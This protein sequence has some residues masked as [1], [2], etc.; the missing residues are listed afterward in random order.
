MELWPEESLA[1]TGHVPLQRAAE[2]PGK[3]V[4]CLNSWPQDSA[5]GGMK[6]S[7][8]PHHDLAE[9]Y[10]IF[11]PLKVEGTAQEHLL[12]RK[13]HSP[14]RWTLCILRDFCSERSQQMSLG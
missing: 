12:K 3:V 14:Q 9:G 11:K 5:K 4:Q 10:L 7:V 2:Q 13:E 8:G 1:G 6:S